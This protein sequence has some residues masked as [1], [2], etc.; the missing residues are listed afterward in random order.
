MMSGPKQ[1]R[2]VARVL[3][4]DDSALMR[5]MLS[6]MLGSDPGIEVVG[7]AQDPYIARE[8]IKELNIEPQFEK[9]RRK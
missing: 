3:I 9:V 1:K 4:V 6:E 8:K 2:D 5:K 7:V